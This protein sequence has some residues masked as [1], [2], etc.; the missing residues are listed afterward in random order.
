MKNVLPNYILGMDLDTNTIIKLDVVK[1][2]GN[3]SE[4]TQEESNETEKNSESEN[5]ENA[6]NNTEKNNNITHLDKDDD[7]RE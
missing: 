7:K 3:S 5:S 1:N 6:E 4:N 2:E